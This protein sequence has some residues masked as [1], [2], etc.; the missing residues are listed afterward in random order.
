MYD[1]Y[2]IFKLL[3]KRRFQIKNDTSEM[4]NEVYIKFKKKKPCTI[5]YRASYLWK[6]VKSKMKRPDFKHYRK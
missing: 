3:S 5:M 2:D 4:I 1:L 6:Y